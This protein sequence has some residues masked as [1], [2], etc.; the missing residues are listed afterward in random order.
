MKASLFTAALACTLASAVTAQQVEQVQP[1]PTKSGAKTLPQTKSGQINL[2]TTSPTGSVNPRAGS[3]MPLVGGA[4]ETCAGATVIAGAG[5][6]SGNNLGAIMETPINCAASVE[7]GDVWYSWT[8]TGATGSQTM[9]MCV[10]TDAAAT[11][12]FDCLLAVYQTS[13]GGA[14]LACNDDGPGCD[15]G[16]GTGTL[17]G[18]WTSTVQFGVTSGNVYKIQIAGFDAGS[19]F[20]N[21]S[22]VIKPVATPP[23]NDACTAPTSIAGAGPHAFDNTNATR[24]AEHQAE[25]G[26]TQFGQAGVNADVWFAW[27][28]GFTASARLSFCALGNTVDTKAGVYAPAGVG[29]CPA[30]APLACIDD[31]CGLQAQVDWPATSGQIYRLQVG[32][33]PGGIAGD[34][35]L[36]VYGGTGT[37]SITPTPTGPP[38]DGCATPAT[39]LLG[40]GPHSF[41][42]STAN[43][44]AE[45]QAEPLCNAI[46]GGMPINNDQWFKWSAFGTGQATLTTC[47]LT[48]VDT[49]VAVYPNP[50]GVTACPS[51]A[52]I[53]CNDDNCFPNLQSSVCFPVTNGVTYVIQMGTFPGAIGGAGQFAISIGASGVLPCKRDDGVGDNMLGWTAGGDMAW[54]QRF[55]MGANFNVSN[56]QVVWGSAAFPGASPANGS[57]ARVLLYEDPNN[58]GDPS[59]VVLKQ[60]VATF[61][62]NV[63]T[64]TYNTISVPSTLM[65]GVFFAGG[66]ELHAAGQF[67][68]PMDQTCPVGDETWFFGDNAAVP[69]TNY[70]NP[71][72]SP[73]PVDSF[74]NNGFPTNLMVR[75]CVLS[76]MIGECFPGTGG[77]INC[78]CPSQNP[79]NPAGGCENHG[80]G[81]TAGGVLG[82]AGNPDLSSDTLIITASGMR[83]TAAVLNVFFSYKPGGATPTPGIVSGAGVRCIG[84]GGSLKRL[85]TGNSAAGSISRPGMGDLSVSAKSAT[86]AGHAIVAG[87]TRH[88]FNVYRDGQASQVVNCNNPAITTNLT[89]MGAVTWVP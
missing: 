69:A 59:D 22:M 11:A 43:T 70:A 66:A 12:D 33:Y 27:T 86:F 58:D 37:F 46:P 28:A 78:P 31:L 13:C 64:D 17:P 80:A 89:N 14:L 34:Q 56:I 76:P 4:A 5:T 9:T 21:Y 54:I 60:N 68:A 71:A 53:G 72:A 84:T 36:G 50:G 75:M 24:G 87:E 73:I 44:G 25:A 77:V 19:G 67:V 62:A 7:V 32:T 85:Y 47:G 65:A 8:N 40:P 49:K 48:T 16:P 1:I 3:F 61:V 55:D 23:A 2:G 10:L 51:A 15:P 35:G 88:Y 38:N 63:D 81:S 45:G 79:S 26:C 41:D 42:T 39:T 57:P 29:V 30:G 18:D 74:L 6:F 82:A 52:A 20:G 83:P